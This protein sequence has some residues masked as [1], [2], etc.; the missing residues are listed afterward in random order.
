VVLT[1]R[2]RIFVW[3]VTIAIVPAAI[4]ILAAVLGPRYEV[5]VGGA[6][7]WEETAATFR[8]VR[9]RTN[10][11]A[12]SPGARLA[13]DR[14]AEQLNTSVRHARQA[15]A[16]SAAFSG[17]LAGAA[18]ALAVLVLGGAVRLAGHLSRQMSR[19]IDELVAWTTKIRHGEPIPDT[20]PV[21]GAPEFGVLRESLRTMAAELERARASEVEGAE[22]RAF[23]DMAKNVAHE[24]KNPLTPIRFAI[25]RL[26]KDAP[27]EHKE[28]LAVLESESDRLETMAR[29]F[30]ELGRLPQGPT[31]P[32]DMGELLEELARGGPDDVAVRVTK[33]SGTPL[34]SGHYE[35]LRRALHN[36]VINAIDAVHEK[37]REKG[38]D[39]ATGEVVL[40]VRMLPDGAA[41]SVE[42]TVR[43]TGAGIRPGDIARVF[44]PHFTTKTH[45]TG[46]GLA[47][48]RQTVRYHGGTISISSEPGRGTTVTVVLPTAQPVETA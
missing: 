45:G 29:D 48:V 30:A 40:G 17:I 15:Q 11:A 28:L 1:F 27:P 10:R 23:R 16:I 44:E 26:A 47:I 19:P 24:L 2:Q 18:I 5:P 25:E 12:L 38:A 22:L 35:P 8:E 46:L 6:Q 41:P 43:D 13:L 39:H 4:A 20:P 37:T 36:L 9:A 21:K 33:E 31:A 34:V 32:V 42:V 3:L 14:H 7:A